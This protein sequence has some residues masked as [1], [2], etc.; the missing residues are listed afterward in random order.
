[1]WS[2]LPPMNQRTAMWSLR[3]TTC[4]FGPPK[5][6]SPRMFFSANVAHAGRKPAT[7]ASRGPLLGVPHADGRRDGGA[8]VFHMLHHSFV[9]CRLEI[10]GRVE[11]VAAADQH[12]DGVGVR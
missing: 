6:G 1:M 5:N 9:A 2:T 3:S 10:V 11:A 12:Q 4:S 8:E 7:K